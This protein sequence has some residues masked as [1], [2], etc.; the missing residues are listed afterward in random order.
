MFLSLEI[1]MLKPN[2][3]GDDIR[4]WGLW[5]VV[6]QGLVAFIKEAPERSLVPSTMWG[7]RKKSAVCSPE[8]GLT[9]AQP[10]WHPDLGLAAPRAVSSK[11]LLFVLIS[12]QVCGFCYSS[13]HRLSRISTY[14][15]LY[16]CRQ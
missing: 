9:R 5:E 1:H 14:C 15:L 12:H 11:F 8:E 13:P 2:L 4:R 16:I 7:H 3:Q 10:C 6:R